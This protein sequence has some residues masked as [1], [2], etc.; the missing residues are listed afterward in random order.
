MATTTWD[1]ANLERHLPDGEVYTVHYT[2]SRQDGDYSAGAYGSIGLAEADPA[3]FIPYDSLT[4]AKALE[5][6]KE[7][8]G[9]EQVKSIESALTEQISQQKT[10]TS[11][12]GTPW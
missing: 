2:V 10:P 7:T 1:I 9:E 3:S 6:V 4:K 11:A 12:S 5:W 8:L